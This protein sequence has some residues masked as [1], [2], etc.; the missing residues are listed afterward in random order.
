VSDGQIRDEAVSA[1]SG[2][3]PGRLPPGFQKIAELKRTMPGRPA[4]VSQMIFTDGLVSLSVFVEPNPS[5]NRAAEASS[6]DGTTAFF[7]R[8]VGEHLV[9][10]MG[11][12][13]PA[14]VQQ[15][16]RSVARRP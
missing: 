6:E 5:P 13:P 10:V 11:E 4:P 12:V 14:T 16:A 2:W 7:V 3:L 1:D 15:V 9:S 8:P